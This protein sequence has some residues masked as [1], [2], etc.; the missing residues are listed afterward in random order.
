[1][2][3]NLE[4]F[5]LICN[6]TQENIRRWIDANIVKYY[7]KDDIISNKDFIFAKGECPVMLV[8]HMDTVHYILPSTIDYDNKNKTI[9]SPQGIGGD[10]RCG[11]YALLYA[12]VN[13]NKKPYV[14][15]TADEESCN[16]S[17]RGAKIAATQLK[18]K[19][20]NVKYLIEV[21]RHGDKQAVFYETTNKDF[22][23][24]ICSFGFK[25]CIGMSSDIRHL[26]KEWNIASTNLSAGY[27]NEHTKG[28]IVHIDYLMYTISKILEMLKDSDNAKYYCKDNPKKALPLKQHK[29]AKKFDN[30]ANL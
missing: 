22:I 4:G 1:M 7:K 29:L 16:G 5:K 15:F 25:E 10:D 19:V 28:E 6:A 30:G 24:Y 2:E 14:L 17:C 9:K 12:I 23:N 8:C 18:D 11:V 13:S 3:F 20:V 26:T 21:D 27:L